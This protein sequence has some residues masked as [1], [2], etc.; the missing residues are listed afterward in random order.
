MFLHLQN[1]DV[2]A[3]KKVLSELKEAK[4][5]NSRLRRLQDKLYNKQPKVE[6]KKN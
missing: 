4:L 5:L 1:S 2:V 6:N 3:A